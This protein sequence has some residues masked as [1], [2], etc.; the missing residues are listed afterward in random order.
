MPRKKEP[1]VEVKHKIIHVTMKDQESG[2]RVGTKILAGE[3]QVIISFD[4]YGDTETYERG[5][6][7]VRVDIFND[8]PVLT[9]WADGNGRKPSHVISLKKA[10]A[11]RRMSK[12]D[13]DHVAPP[14]MGSK[15]KR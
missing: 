1:V 14:G 3:D 5:Y 12:V 13:V 8:E 10:L 15:E 11:G 2:R 7:V 4:G 6:A 9:V